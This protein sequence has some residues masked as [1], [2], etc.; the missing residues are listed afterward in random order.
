MESYL[1]FVLGCMGIEIISTKVCKNK[2]E[3]KGYR[4]D[5]EKNSFFGNIL[6]FIR[7]FLK[8]CIPIQ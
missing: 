8:N 6:G 7:I 5:I 4:F 2:L 1:L 3:K